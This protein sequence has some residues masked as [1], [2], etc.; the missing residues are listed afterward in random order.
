VALLPDFPQVRI[1]AA[2]LDIREFDLA[3]AA[4]VDEVPR[5]G[6]WLPLSTALVAVPGHPGS[7]QLHPRSGVQR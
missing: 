6:A 5:R 7:S 1:N 4:L 3:D 2:R